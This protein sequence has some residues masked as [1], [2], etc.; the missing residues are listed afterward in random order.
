MRVAVAVLTYNRLA[1]LKRTLASLELGGYPYTLIVVDN[2]SI[3]GTA[4]YVTSIGGYCN[5]DGNH[6]MGYGGNQAVR[7]ALLTNPDIVLLTADDVAYYPGWLA[8]LVDFWQHAPDT[9]IIAATNLE[10]DYAWNKVLGVVDAGG[11]RALLRASVP[12]DKWSFRAAD[13]LKIGPIRAATGDREDLEICDRLI[14]QGY[15]LAALDLSEHI[16]ERVSAWG[17]L[18]WTIAK[19]LDRARW[20]V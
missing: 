2:G 5:R 20:G 9:V 17:N 13:W 10:P 7:L 15:G 18:S 16:G 19:P 12:G 3:D 4:E 8:R 11:E 14:T 6:S 1:L